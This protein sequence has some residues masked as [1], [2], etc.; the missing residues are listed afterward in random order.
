VPAFAAGECGR[1]VQDHFCG[2]GAKILRPWRLILIKQSFN[3]NL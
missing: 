3:R 1:D 2:L